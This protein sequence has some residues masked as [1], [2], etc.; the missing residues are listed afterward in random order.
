MN[1]QWKGVVALS[2]ASVLAFIV[3]L[4]LHSLIGAVIILVSTLVVSFVLGISWMRPAQ[5][6]RVSRRKQAS[7]P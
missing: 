6:H 4:G 7:L 3:A 2:S 1:R 5:T